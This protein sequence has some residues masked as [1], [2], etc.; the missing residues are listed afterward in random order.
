MAVKPTA[1]PTIAIQQQACEKSEI[2][3]VTWHTLRHTFASCL[4]DRGS[5]S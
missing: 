1:W 5:T 3:G 4:L 2:T